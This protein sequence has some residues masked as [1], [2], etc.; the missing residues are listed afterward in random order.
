[1]VIRAIN[2]TPNSEFDI[3]GHALYLIL[4]RVGDADY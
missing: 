2:Q 1:M 3:L 4:N